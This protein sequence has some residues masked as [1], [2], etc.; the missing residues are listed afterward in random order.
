MQDLILQ[1]A[2]FP[3]L[4]LTITWARPPVFSVSV[5]SKEIKVICFYRFTEA[6]IIK[7]LTPEICTKIV[8]VL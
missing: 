4:W 6:L 2:L 7:D 1:E 8:Q 3:R 5:H